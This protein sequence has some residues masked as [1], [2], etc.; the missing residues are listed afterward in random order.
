[1]FLSCPRTEQ[2]T[3]Q[4][5][6]RPEISGNKDEVASM[7]SRTLSG[8]SDV[9]KAE[10]TDVHRNMQGGAEM[11]ELLQSGAREYR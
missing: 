3:F 5:Q 1:M 2:E 11:A 10:R 4:E 9:Q 7:L 8:D 6:P